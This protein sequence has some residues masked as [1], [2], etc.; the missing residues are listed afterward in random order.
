MPLGK[1]VVHA[2]HDTPY[3][4]GIFFG[5]QPELVGVIGGEENIGLELYRAGAI[6]HGFAGLFISSINKLWVL[7]NNPRHKTRV[8]FCRSDA[9]FKK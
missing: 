8:R 3:L 2:F 4:F 1:P 6:D 5:K 7:N 9:P